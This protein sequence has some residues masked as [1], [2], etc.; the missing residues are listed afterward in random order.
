MFLGTLAIANA[1][2]RTAFQA[3]LAAEQM[4]SNKIGAPVLLNEVS[5]K[6]SAACLPISQNA[7][8]NLLSDSFA[9][10]YLFGSEDNHAFVLVSGS[11]LL[12]AVIGYSIE[13][14]LS[15]D[16]EEWPQNLVSWLD[17]VSSVEATFEND[18][19][20]LAEGCFYSARQTP[21]V[22]PLLTS[23]WGQSW[24]YNEKCP[25]K[26]GTRS[27][28]GC[29]ATSISQV[30]NY[31]HYPTQP[32]GAYTYYDLKKIK[33]TINFDEIS[34]DYDLML[35]S[36]TKSNSTEEQ[37][38]EVAELMY[39]VGHS[40]S[41]SYDPSG[42][43]A[44]AIMA[45]RAFVKNLGCTKAAYLMR[46]YYSLDEWN[47]ILQS[48][49]SASRPIVMNGQSSSGGHSFVVDGIDG[50]GMYHVDWGWNGSANGYFDVSILN[51]EERGTGTS[52][53]EDGFSSDQSI[54]IGV[55][56]PNDNPTYHTQVTS[57]SNSIAIDKTST[58][59]GGSVRF[60]TK[61]LN[62]GASSVTGS[63]GVVLFTENGDL[64]ERSMSSNNITLGAT[65]YETHSDGNVY[66]A[67]YDEKNVSYTYTIPT[68]LADGTY[69]AYICLQPEGS[70]EYDIIRCRHTQYSYREFSVD[71]DEVTFTSPKFSP[72][73]S[74]LDWDY[75]EGSEAKTGNATLCVSIR[76]DGDESL[77]GTYILELTSPM[78]D[79]QEASPTTFT[80]APSMTGTAKFAVRYSREGEWQ[81]HLKVKNTCVSNTAYD[82]ET[83][84]FEVGYDPTTGS[85]FA[86]SKKLWAEGTVY[87]VGT[88][89]FKAVLSNAGSAYDGVMAVRLYNS[90]TAAADKNL[91]ASIES[92][93]QF[94]ENATD[95]V[96][97]SG[98]FNLANMKSASATVYARLFYLCGE[99]MLQISTSAVAVTVVKRDESA[100][101]LIYNENADDDSVYDMS[102]KQVTS[103]K[104]L[105]HGLFIVNGIPQYLR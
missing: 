24:P 48:E 50:N 36:Y 31:H 21:Q 43:S 67:S 34:F 44:M 97:I 5:L 74:V 70:E 80:L 37:Q 22:N 33:R 3:K 100:I 47:D 51:P 79:T 56:D 88:S 82:L 103:D 66:Y 16:M 1:A 60:S 38:D 91:L 96:T 2:N 58:T 28:T 76:N 68:D 101:E 19:S 42:S 71:G 30:L 75:N 98:D 10:F 11:D 4:I 13:G 26:D 55:C 39:A 57:V 72:R 45:P 15:S 78:G 41:M 92:P 95:T 46:E 104:T 73:L 27:V 105:L 89:T 59:K 17:Y 93:I 87:N 52:A 102:G 25:E 7:I 94:A 90:K 18:P 20:L 29:M 14:N 86:V 54:F 6:G 64:V 9:P 77:S 40:V 84:T 23:K 12:P 85:D 61:A 53:S 99:E 81:A 63:L 35:D 8:G 69:R 83:V 65:L 49:L 32:K 62:Q